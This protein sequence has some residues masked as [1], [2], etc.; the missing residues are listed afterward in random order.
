MFLG[1]SGV[2]ANMP[3]ETFAHS[4]HFQE[5]C[6]QGTR[7]KAKGAV[8]VSMHDAA[9]QGFKEVKAFLKQGVGQE[10][11][12]NEIEQATGLA[13][14]ANPLL[15]RKLVQHKKIVRREI[16]RFSVETDQL[17]KCLLFSIRYCFV[18]VIHA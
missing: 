3:R 1:N 6:F 12:I 8:R 10:F 2:P 7:Q 4:L 9:G 5:S 16:E 18:L 17:E 11:S 15:L 13:L 14:L